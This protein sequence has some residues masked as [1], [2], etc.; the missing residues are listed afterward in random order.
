MRV[1]K[2]FNDEKNWTDYESGSFKL[3][4]LA[5]YRNSDSGLARMKDKG[6]GVHD[7]GFGSGTGVIKN[8]VLPGNI[9]ID[10][11]SVSGTGNWIGTNVTFNEHVLCVSKG[12]YS[13]SHHEE[14]MAGWG[15]GFEDEYLGNQD[16][17]SFAVIDLGELLYGLRCWAKTSGVLNSTEP[18]KRVVRSRS[19]SYGVERKSSYEID[20]IWKVWQKMTFEDYE[21]AIFSKPRVFQREKELRVVVSLSCPLTQQNDVAPHFPKNEILRKAVKRLGRF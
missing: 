18:L 8:I 21:K 10:N 12:E 15:T 5:E 9:R 2:Y 7:Q 16:L 11:L 13:R 3:G 1:V 6:E 14:M 4:T 19:V 20:D 17:N